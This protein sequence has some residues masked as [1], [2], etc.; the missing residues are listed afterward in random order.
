M[1]AGN[2]TVEGIKG[3]EKMNLFILSIYDSGYGATMFENGFKINLEED[4]NRA[5]FIRRFGFSPEQ[6]FI[7]DL[8]MTLP[9]NTKI[10]LC[11]DGNIEVADT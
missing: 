8:Q 7:K 2:E 11:V 4:D 5:A 6:A 3:E 10:I 1:E 9:P